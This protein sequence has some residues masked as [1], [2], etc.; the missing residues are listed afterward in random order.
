M[1]ISVYRSTAQRLA[2]LDLMLELTTQPHSPDV[3]S[4]G[5]NLHDGE[6]A[7]VTCGRRTF[8]VDEDGAVTEQGEVPV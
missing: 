5:P 4:L 7:V 6:H 8:L 2:V 3:N 1:T